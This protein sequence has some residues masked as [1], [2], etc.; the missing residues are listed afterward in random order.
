MTARGAAHAP[1]R[2][3]HVLFLVGLVLAT[4]VGCD[5][6]APRARA[7]RIAASAHLI[8]GPKAIGQIGDYLLENDQVRIV[9][10]DMLKHLC[11]SISY[12][13][14]GSLGELR[15]RFLAE[16]ERYLVRLS[17]SARHESFTR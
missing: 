6:P 2:P 17:T 16:P 3:W 11:S 15:A 13:G 4:G 5:G 8:G 10:H 12:G 14:A 9:I 7:Q 1:P